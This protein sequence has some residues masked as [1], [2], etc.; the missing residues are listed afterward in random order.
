MKW[1][2]VKASLT[3]TER[4]FAEWPLQDMLGE[5]GIKSPDHFRDYALN[6]AELFGNCQW[7]LMSTLH[8][9]IVRALLPRAIQIPVL[10]RQIMAGMTAAHYSTHVSAFSMP[11]LALDNTQQ[12]LWPES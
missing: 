3:A 2:N 10:D 6:A 8:I 9:F 1:D 11:W 4:A 7:S 12:K 5:I